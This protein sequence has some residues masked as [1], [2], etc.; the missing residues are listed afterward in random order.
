[1]PKY[2][3]S[4]TAAYV[5]SVD[6]EAGNAIA[7]TK[8]AR[9]QLLDG[10]TSPDLSFSGYTHIDNAELVLDDDE[11]QQ[12][13]DAAQDE[14]DSGVFSSRAA[15]SLSEAINAISLLSN[16]VCEMQQQ[17]DELQEKLSGGKS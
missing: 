11:V 9:Q 15:R 2:S 14:L 12:H 3:V 17:I 7:A 8:L 4:V 1:M 13:L 16:Q 6:V 10:R 5:G